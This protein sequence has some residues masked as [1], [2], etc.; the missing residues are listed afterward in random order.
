MLHELTTNPNL[1]ILTIIPSS[2]HTTF[3]IINLLLSP[4]NNDFFFFFFW[5]ISDYTNDRTPENNNNNN[6]SNSNSD[7]K[8]L[9]FSISEDGQ[10]TISESDLDNLINQSI[11]EWQQLQ[12]QKSTEFELNPTA[13]PI[14]THLSS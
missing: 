7:N 1:S 4:G 3:T 14:I 8:Q 11:N 12:Q 13:T 6:N 2:V 9:Q 10:Q 5:N